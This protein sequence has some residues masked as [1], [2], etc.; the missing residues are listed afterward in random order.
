MD[1]LYRSE[2]LIRALNHHRHD[3]MNDLQVLFGYIQL[4]KQ[5]KLKAYIEKL[6]DKLYRESLVSKLGVPELVAYLVLFRTKQR[7]MELTVW[8]EKDINLGAFGEA[9][10]TTADGI[11]KIVNAY[12]EAAGYN[13]EN[14]NV[15]VVTLDLLGDER[16]GR[17]L[18]INF[19]YTGVYNSDLLLQAIRGTMELISSLDLGSASCDFQEGAAD[20]E[21]RLRLT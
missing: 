16:N 2:D 21:L 14:A 18:I 9:G 20:I 12:D 19:E 11:M 10:L 7:W 8:P 17:T 6:S 5:D 1:N 4:N 3:W 13:D 15:L